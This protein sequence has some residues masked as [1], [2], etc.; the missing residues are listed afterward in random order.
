MPA[1]PVNFGS[2][3]PANPACPIPTGESNMLRRRTFP[4]LGAATVVSSA[5]HAIASSGSYPSRRVHL[6]VGF[7]AGGNTDIVARIM[8][9]WLSEQLGQPF[10]VENRTGAA[11]NM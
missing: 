2:R 6:V 10:V 4:Q 3:V 1:W 9:K 8:G 5:G 11:T 7:S